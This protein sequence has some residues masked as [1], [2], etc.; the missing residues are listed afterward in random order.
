MPSG[1]NRGSISALGVDVSRRAC[2]PLRG[3]VHRSPPYSNATSSRLTAGR[4]S[5]RVPCA[6]A[7]SHSARLARRARAIDV[8][9]MMDAVRDMDSLHSH[10][11]DRV[12]S[13]PLALDVAA[14]CRCCA[15]AVRSPRSAA[16][17][18][19]PGT[20]ARR[21]GSPLRCWRRIASARLGCRCVHASVIALISAI[22]AT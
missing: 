15:A 17:A 1:E 21:I 7:A 6:S 5:S 9:R 22:G 16:A 3:T 20:S 10:F 13:R 2:P 14:G 4:R 18:A 12:S 11:D 19:V 8:N